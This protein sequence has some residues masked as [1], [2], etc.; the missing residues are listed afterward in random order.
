[1]VNCITQPEGARS[2]APTGVRL[3]YVTQCSLGS[4]HLYAAALGMSA[5]MVLEPT[6]VVHDAGSVTE[7]LAGVVWRTPEHWADNCGAVPADGDYVRLLQQ[8][9]GFLPAWGLVVTP[10]D[11]DGSANC[12]LP[13]KLRTAT[14]PVLLVRWLLNPGEVD[15][16][17]SSTRVGQDT[18]AGPLRALSTDWFGVMPLASVEL[19]ASR[20]LEL[21]LAASLAAGYPLYREGQPPAA[22]ASPAQGGLFACAATLPVTMSGVSLLTLPA[23]PGFWAAVSEA[24]LGVLEAPHT[25]E[26]LRV[27]T[28]VVCRPG[29]ALPSSC[30]AA[31]KWVKASVGRPGTLL[32]G[33]GQLTT[34]RGF[35]YLC[36]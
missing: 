4:V 21:D 15:R 23:A 24:L 12:E 32:E 33:P 11:P 14:E 20:G 5:P 10:H 22:A 13:T 25:L 27:S 1:M 9:P 17:R 35:R 26:L 3:Q 18:A 34:M 16:S 29:P 2:S 6:A 28:T 8:A 7:R 36:R 30:C 19:A 31:A